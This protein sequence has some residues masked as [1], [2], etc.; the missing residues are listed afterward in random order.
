MHTL[1]HPAIQSVVSGPAAA[2][3]AAA[4]LE[5]LLEMQNLRLHPRPAESVSAF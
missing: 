5:N 4:S 1:Q 3:A 2:A